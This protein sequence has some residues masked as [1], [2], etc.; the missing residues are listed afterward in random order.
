MIKWWRGRFKILLSGHST[1]NIHQ[2]YNVCFR[3]SSDLL[4]CSFLANINSTINR[5]RI[6]DLSQSNI[7]TITVETVQAELAGPDPDPRPFRPSPVQYLS[8]SLTSKQQEH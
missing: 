7:S 3:C 8:M 1:L 2:M 6:D 5:D 4:D